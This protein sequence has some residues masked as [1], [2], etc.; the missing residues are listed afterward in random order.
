MRPLACSIVLLASG[1]AQGGAPVPGG[2]SDSGRVRFLLPLD[3]EAPRDVREKLAR[4]AE[5]AESKRL[6]ARG[7]AG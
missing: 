4:L 5:L 1:F 7:S 3:D 2:T 6:S